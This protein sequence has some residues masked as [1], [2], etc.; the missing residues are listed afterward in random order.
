MA[1]SRRILGLAAAALVGCGE[2]CPPPEGEWRTMSQIGGPGVRDLPAVVWTGEEMI[3][4]GGLRSD[5]RRADGVRYR[6]ASDE[7]VAMSEGPAALTGTA[8]VWTGAEMIVWESSA[9]GA[10]YDPAA[11]AWRSLATDGQ[12]AEVALPLAVWTGSEVIVLDQLVPG[13][14]RYDPAADH[15]TSIANE[16]LPAE[17]LLF[18]AV[19][20]GDELIVWG[21]AEEVAV[22]AYRYQPA[23]DRWSPV[24]ANDAMSGAGVWTG[25]EIFFAGGGGV[26]ASLRAAGFDPATG[27]WRDAATDCGPSGLISQSIV[28]TG[29]RA[30]VWG[31]TAIDSRETREVASGA[32]YDR[33]TDS[34]TPMVD[35]GAPSP[36][37]RAAGLWTGSELL[38]WGGWVGGRWLP[39]GAR[40]TPASR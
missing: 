37:A 3:V 17:M 34:W 36:R 26:F 20:A 4:W 2:E 5:E 1:S 22:A 24:E 40:F 27:T 30:I 14:G 10:A 39:D 7:W 15:W 18:G 31:G 12:P 11:D 23:S 16:G 6:P 33:E 13:G 29:S 9:P 32:I 28:W 25:R 38:V 21:A 19:W 8:A 35:E